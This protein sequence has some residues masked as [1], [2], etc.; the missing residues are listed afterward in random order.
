[1]SLFTTHTVSVERATITPDDVGGHSETWATVYD[2][3]LGR[4]QAPRE[5]SGTREEFDKRDMRQAFTLY[6]PA[7]LTL[8]TGDRVTVSGVSGYFL[9]ESH[10][11]PSGTGRICHVYLTKKS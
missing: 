2:S 3:Y 6:H 5:R 1:M 11:D 8:L 9:V 4:L 10:G 7:E